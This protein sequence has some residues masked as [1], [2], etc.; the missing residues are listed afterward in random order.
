MFTKKPLIQALPYAGDSK[1]PPIFFLVNTPRYCDCDNNIESVLGGT[2]GGLGG[3]VVGYS[4]YNSLPPPHR[5]STKTV[6]YLIY[7]FFVEPSKMALL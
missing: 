2:L 5:K 7:I 6:R 1:I 3:D 4:T